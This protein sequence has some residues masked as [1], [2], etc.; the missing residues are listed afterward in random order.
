MATQ[1]RKKKNKKKKKNGVPPKKEKKKKKKQKQ[2]KSAHGENRGRIELLI[3][4]RKTLSPRSE[5]NRVS[6]V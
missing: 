5:E 4:G 6:D 2:K 3:N 1:K